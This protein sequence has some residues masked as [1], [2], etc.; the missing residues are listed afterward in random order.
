MNSK[1]ISLKAEKR[2]VFGRKVKQLRKK[3]IL[4]ANIYGKKVKSIALQLALNDFIEVFDKAGETQIVEISIDKEKM[5]RSVL[6][7]RVQQ[8]PVDDSYL[9]V[10]FRQVS[11]T[12]KIEAD[13]PLEI[14]GESPAAGKGGVQVQ[15]VDIIR[16]KA[17]PNELPEKFTLD[18]SV[19]KEIGDNLS[20]KDLKY[21][22]SKI[23]ILIEDQEKMLVKIEEPAKE[24]EPAPVVEETVEGEVKEGEE[25]EEEAKE[26]KTEEKPAE[27]KPAEE[28]KE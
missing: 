2:E 26:G 20:L 4:P 12:E 7:H 14:E 5:A 18:V 27:E 19:L 24:E 10:D 13:V 25:K 17:L 9:H 22:K 6:V 23:E 16:V 21:D 11:L 28:K 8:D 3:S 1:K 15:L